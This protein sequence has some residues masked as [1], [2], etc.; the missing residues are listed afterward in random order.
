MSQKVNVNQKKSGRQALIIVCALIVGVLIGGIGMMIYKDLNN[1][2]TKES[3]EGS[4]KEDDRADKL[5]DGEVYDFEKAGYIKLG[6]YKGLKADVQPEDDDVYAEMIAST[7]ETKVSDDTVADGD[8]VCIDFT[9]KMN[10]VKL[11]EASGEDIYVWI[12]KGEYVDDFEK[13]MIGMENGKKQTIDCKFPD[14]YDDEDLA[15][16]TV[17]FTIHI[18]GK[19][20]NKAAEQFSEG[21]NKTVQEY[22]DAEKARQLEENR[23]SKGELVWDEVRSN[24]KVDSVP[25]QMLARVTEEVTKMYTDFAQMSGMEVDEL[26]ANFEMDEDGINEI[27]NETVVD[28]MVAKT[29]AAKEGVT[30]D[31]T[32]YRQA[33]MENLAIEETDDQAGSTLEE[34]ENE[35]KQGTGGRPKDDML[36][37]RVK[38]FVGENTA[39]ME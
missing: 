21:Q 8:V 23:A 33:L 29:I 15:G 3:Q 11:E 6:K 9:G 34:L 19:F 22:F 35:Y 14:D 30:M 5:A 4:K 20:G 39:E 28:I 16:K 36:V 31:D 37:E 25:E 24:A 7:E 2:K 1:S 17:Q 12:G 26:L 38:D 13:G 18:K 27:A 10:G 32:Y